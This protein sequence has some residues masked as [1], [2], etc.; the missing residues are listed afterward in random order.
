MQRHTADA[1][2]T[3]V[4]LLGVPVWVVLSYF[5]LPAAVALAICFSLA[6]GFIVLTVIANLFGR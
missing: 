5:W 3:W 1:L 4:I 2:V 6:I